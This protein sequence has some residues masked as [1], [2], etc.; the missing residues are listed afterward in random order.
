MKTADSIHEQ[1]RR[2]KKAH[3]EP[4]SVTV[5]GETYRELGKPRR[6]S[7]IPVDCDITMESGWMVR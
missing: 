2:M 3:V 6:M 5:C 1:I 7:G 4:S